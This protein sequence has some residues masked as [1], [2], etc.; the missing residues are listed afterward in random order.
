MKL[1]LS[2]QP[3]PKFQFWALLTCF[4]FGMRGI[5]GRYCCVAIRR[6]PGRTF[7]CS[8]SCGT[9]FRC[10]FMICACVVSHP[11]QSLWM[12]IR[13]RSIQ[14]LIEI[15]NTPD[16]DAWFSLCVSVGCDWSKIAEWRHVHLR[17]GISV[18]KWYPPV[19]ELPQIKEF[20][21]SSSWILRELVAFLDFI[22]ASWFQNG[23]GFDRGLEGR[24]T[25]LTG[26]TI[27][28]GIFY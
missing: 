2:A 15:Q 19:E 4:K 7:W 21:L 8:D 10:P 13:A 23:D 12:G 11:Q 18:C 9:V 17:V 22:V 20:L 1:R 6:P 3:H 25:W 27:K 16:F 24:N 5:A 26:R 28:K 14:F